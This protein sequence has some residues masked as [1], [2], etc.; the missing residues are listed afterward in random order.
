MIKLLTK[1]EARRIAANVAMLS[2]LLNP[3]RAGIWSRRLL[4]SF[5][6]SLPRPGM[7]SLGSSLHHLLG[8]GFVVPAAP[9]QSGPH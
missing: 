3:I 1:D 6:S 7:L 9:Y 5:R 2:E 4:V 8:L